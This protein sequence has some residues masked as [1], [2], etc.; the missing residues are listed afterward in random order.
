MRR[1]PLLVVLVA[2]VALLGPVPT[3]DAQEVVEFTGQGTDDGACSEFQDGEAPAGRQIWQFNLNPTD[4]PADARLTAEFS[5][6]TSITDLAP[7]TA[8]GASAHW[9]V[10][11][12]LEA[13]VVSASATHSGHQGNTQLVVSHCVAGEPN[14]E[15]PN[16]IP[17][18]EEP[19]DD[20]PP[21]T[22]PPAPEDQPPVPDT[23]PP[24]PDAAQQAPAPSAVPTAEAIVGEPGFT[25]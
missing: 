5:D 14:G 24:E 8:Q 1:F 6:G 7:T 12:D 18:E 10:E 23:Q 21:D 4:D 2:A 15:P 17:P 9:L 11:T 13:T 25:G 22:Q 20:V 16:G 19:P 3:A